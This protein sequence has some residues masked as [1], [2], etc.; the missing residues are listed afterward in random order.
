MDAIIQITADGFLPIMSGSDGFIAYF[1]LPVGDMLAAISAF[2][3]AE[4]AAASNDA[5]R[6]FVA[7]NLA[8]L[9]PNSPTIIKGPMDT[10]FFARLDE[11]MNMIDATSLF[12]SLRIYAEVN[13]TRRA[14]TTAIV[15]SGFPA[16][17][18]G[19]GGFLG[20]RPLAR[21]RKPFS[22]LEHL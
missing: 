15:Q 3:T 2:E 13:L 14:Q 1:L 18:A 22:C 11:S 8:P 16:D 5:A 17:I 12:A 19:G 20:L 10:A 21:R 4:Q 9:L 7:E 6:S